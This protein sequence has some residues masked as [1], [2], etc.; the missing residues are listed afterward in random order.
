VVVRV[1]WRS[2]MSFLLVVAALTWA[3]CSW[4][5]DRLP[6][7]HVTG[8]V[9][10][11]GKPAS[12]AKIFFHPAANVSVLNVLR[13]FGEVSEDGTFELSTYL[14]GDGAPAGDYV[15]TVYWPAPKR[16]FNGKF[17]DESMPPDLL[18][19]LYSNPRTSKLRAQ[20]NPGDNV[21]EPF[22]LP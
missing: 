6:I 22:Q 17:Q 10:V 18:K 12:G 15:V 14:A 4:K 19:N 1:S 11:A 13:P 9:F 16:A 5:S 20:I 3:G 7:N 2:T 8:S 21:L